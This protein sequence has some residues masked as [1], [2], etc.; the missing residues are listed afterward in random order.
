M[1]AGS[2]HLVIYYVISFRGREYTATS[3]GVK[4]TGDTSSFLYYD[5]TCII[6]TSIHIVTH[7][8]KLYKERA[9]CYHL[10]TSEERR[11]RGTDIGRSRRD[12]YRCYFDDLVGDIETANRV[13]NVREV[14]RLTKALTGRGKHLET[15]C[16]TKDVDGKPLTE[17][18]QLL[19]AWQ[20]FLG[21][22]LTCADIPGA[23][24]AQVTADDDND[25]DVTEVELETC[26]R[27]LHDN[28]TP[29][30]DGIPIEEYRGLPAAKQ[31]PFAIVRLMWKTEMTHQPLYAV[32]V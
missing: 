20:E 14:A 19:D 10:L 26:M 11:R 24:Y 18:N 5:L 7:T 30:C 17:W 9:R 28:K 25:E 6:Q 16:L 15:S 1:L 22:R 31:E 8:K 3:H 2:S 29:G 12:D 32:L 23:A 13:G 27:V 4:N 21:R